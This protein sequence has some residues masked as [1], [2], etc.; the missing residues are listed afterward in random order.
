MILKRTHW[1]YSSRNS[2]KIHPWETWGS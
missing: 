1:V 2:T